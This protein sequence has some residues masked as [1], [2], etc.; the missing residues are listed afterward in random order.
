MLC[1]MCLACNNAKERN[2]GENFKVKEKE[3]VQCSMVDLVVSYPLIE[4]LKKDKKVDSYLTYSLE[5]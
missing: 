1:A 2:G 3:I 4:Q 5:S